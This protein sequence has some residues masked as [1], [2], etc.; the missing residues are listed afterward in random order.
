M[1]EFFKNYYGPFLMKPITKLCVL[2]IFVVYMG[3]SILGCLNITEGLPPKLLVLE[4]YYSARYYD[5][6]DQTFWTQGAIRFVLLLKL[7][8]TLS[9]SAIIHSNTYCSGFKSNPI[10]NFNA[11]I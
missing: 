10:D 9:V 7:S 4:N 6:M 3:I 1:G 8:I 2:F 5:M 11:L